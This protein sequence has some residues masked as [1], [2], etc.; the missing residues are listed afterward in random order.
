MLPKRSHY[1][2]NWVGLELEEIEKGL[3]LRSYTLNGDATSAFML[4]NPRHR[5]RA[6]HKETGRASETPEPY[7][8]KVSNLVTIKSA[9][10][11]WRSSGGTR[12]VRPVPTRPYAS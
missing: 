4:Q 12:E 9:Y 6:A 5:R 1:A 7:E 3:P 10:S 11:S 2:I 8:A